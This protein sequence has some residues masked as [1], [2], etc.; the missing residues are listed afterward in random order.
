MKTQWL[1]ALVISLAVGLVPTGAD[2]KRLGGG[3][4]SGMQR[5]MP[6]RTAPDAAPAK[7][8]AAPTQQA[9]PATP[10]AAP[11]AAPKRNWMG[12]L[13]GLAAGLGLAALFSHFGMGE[14]MGS[15][16]MMALLAVAAFFVIRL[17]MRRF[18]PQP[19]GMPNGN[20]MARSGAQVAWPTPAAPSTPT[21]PVEP[22]LGSNAAPEAAVASR[23]RRA[24]GD[25]RLRAGGLRQR[26]FCAHR[27]DDLH[28]PAGRQ[29]QRRPR[30][31]AP[32]HDARD[33]CRDCAW[34]CRTAA[35]PSSRPT[36]CMSTRRCS[37]WPTMASAR[38]SA[39][40]STARCVEEAG[41]APLAFDEVWH[42]VKPHDDSRAWA[43]AGIEQQPGKA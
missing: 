37:T 25:P 33:V 7:P 27:E 31:P 1:A 13:A 40:A 8:A 10:G 5:D 6:A 43:I 4:S 24:R 30:R 41:A 29:R 26:R 32:L 17:L 11:A 15:F 34:T 42:L 28:P 14:G 9:A 16:L 3:K 22:M 21:A 20:T 39:C 19:A 35:R 23:G 18:A 12:P 38:S 2:A 36:W